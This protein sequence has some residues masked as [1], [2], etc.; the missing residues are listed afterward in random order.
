MP[1]LWN[2]GSIQGRLCAEMQQS[3]AP[4]VSIG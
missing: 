2:P 3:I 1:H 4:L